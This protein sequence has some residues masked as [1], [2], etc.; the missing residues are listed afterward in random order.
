MF[1]AGS[2][3]YHDYY[4]WPMK[5]KKVFEEWQEKTS[6]GQLFATYKKHGVFPGAPQD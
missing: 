3:V 1:V 4:R 2:E 6:W 5:D